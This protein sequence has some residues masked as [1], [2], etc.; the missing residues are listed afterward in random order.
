MAVYVNNI[1]VNCGT[2][3]TQEY[4]LF[5][6]GGK[7]ID[8]SNFSGAAALRK[9]RGSA[10]SVS[11]T[12]KFVDRAK[13]KLS[14]FIPSWITSNLKP[15]RYLYDVKLTSPSGAK[16][17]ILEGNVNARAGISTGCNFSLPTSAQRLCI[18]VIDESSSMGWSQSE[19]KWAEFRTT[20]PNR[21]YY[22]LMPTGLP[23]HAGFGL[24][25][26][27]YHYDTLKCSDQFLNE[28][29]VNVPPLI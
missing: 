11:F 26:T 24:T 27:N 15:G 7:I 8:L 3:F 28:T 9:H 4:D 6:T 17:I 1:T 2:D 10:T 20:Y 18:G 5:E 21:T 13:G 14:L 16:S 19:T 23:P 25:V 12:V 22:L 29:T